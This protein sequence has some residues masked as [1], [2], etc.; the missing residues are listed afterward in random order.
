ML[1]PERQLSLIDFR[2]LD[3]DQQ[4]DLL[5]DF[6]DTIQSLEIDVQGYQAI[7][8]HHREGMIILIEIIAL[9]RRMN[10]QAELSPELQAKLD[11]F[12]SWE[13]SYGC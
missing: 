9:L 13:D 6:L 8:R 12:K 11:Q 1:S 10:P 5:H 7:D 2:S 3:I 4:E